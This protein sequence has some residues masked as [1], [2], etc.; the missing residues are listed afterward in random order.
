ME[1][2]CLG[3]QRLLVDYAVLFFERPLH[4]LLFQGCIFIVIPLLNSFCNATCC[5]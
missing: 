5:L 3:S 2:R 4:E 1:R